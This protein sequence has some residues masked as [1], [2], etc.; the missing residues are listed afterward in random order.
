MTTQEI[1][2]LLH[3]VKGHSPKWIACCPAHED[4]HP[5]L[6]IRQ[7]DDGRTLL[8]CHAGCT[9]EAICQALGLRSAELFEE[10]TGPKE[11]R[12][13]ESGPVYYVT[14][15]QA[16]RELERRHGQPAKWWVYRN[17]GGEAMMLVVRWDGQGGKEI[18]PISRFEEGWRIAS[19]P[20]PRPLFQ[21]P[22]LAAAETIYVVEGE[23]CAERLAQ[24]GVVASTSAGGSQAAN[25]SDWSPV[26]GK[27][28]VI[29]PDHDAAG[30]SY[31]EQVA[32]LCRQ[33]GA[34]SIKIIRLSEYAPHLPEG[35]DVADLLDDP[36]W[37]GLPLGE[38][39]S[40]ND[41]LRWLQAQAANTPRWQAPQDGAEIRE[42]LEYRPFPVEAL[43]EPL[44]SFVA[45]SSQAMGC[46][47]C[48]IALPLLCAVASLIG[49][50]RML[51]LK[52]TWLV[53]PILW[54]AIVGE[55]GS[56]K[57]PSFRLALRELR[58]RQ[59]LAHH[60]FTLAQQQYQALLEEL[61]QQPRAEELPSKPAPP[62]CR[63]YLVNDVTMEALAPI[64]QENP[65]G[66]LLE[67]DELAAWFGSFDRYGSKGKGGDA[68]RWLSIF[69]AEPITIDRKTHL[70]GPIYIPRPMV[71]V[72][73][74][75]QPSIL[76]KALSDEHRQNGL[77]ARLLFAF[78]PRAAKV[79]TEDDLDD[80][81][82]LQ[83]ENVFDRLEQLATETAQ[84]HSA[85]QYVTLDASAKPLWIDY[86]NQHNHEQT[87]L[88]GELAAAWS[89]LEECAARLALV[90]HCV[91]W[92]A[93]THD[94][95]TSLDA[96]SM[97]QGITLAEWFKHE[98]KRIYAMLNESKDDETRRKLTEFIQRKG[99]SV[100]P[101]EVQMGCR[102]LRQKDDAE[103]AL[104]QLV[105]LGLGSWQETSLSKSNER[106][107][108]QFQLSEVRS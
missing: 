52:R 33:A 57:S 10:R 86:Y 48:Y 65:R 55:S 70:E 42:N 66:L 63:R 61:D 13:G 25:K 29:L 12:R 89:K 1:L 15:H 20:A 67:A 100:T 83:L 51:M 105:A 69:N 73:G 26:R 98:A 8:K 93:G 91:R 38:S 45:S 101:R 102:W 64:L 99:G 49:Q 78:P 41:F 106:K 85:C 104:E 74:G 71:C 14:Y 97:Q 6:S 36:E 59:A 46:D 24:C 23:K 92:A 34:D 80:H 21:L 108:R 77:A 11:R 28:V 4:R 76:K 95:S 17:E 27:A 16:L 31:A 53:P 30:E 94:D 19:L 75:I 72:V 68:A 35:G 18:R 5:S 50:T 81:N 88:E 54:A 3:G 96:C 90:L 44:R 84:A 56:M 82:C 39:A 107:T 47:P 40:P 62:Q 103:Q 9:I 2:Q 87:Q 32:R 7:G 58:K 79:W 37:C 43:P 22:Q 60:E